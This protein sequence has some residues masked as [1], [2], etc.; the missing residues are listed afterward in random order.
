MKIEKLPEAKPEPPKAFAK[1]KPERVTV[2][3]N[4]KANG[5]LGQTARPYANDVAAWV[6]KGWAVK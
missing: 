4:S 6:A 1:P 3:N 5:V 2:V